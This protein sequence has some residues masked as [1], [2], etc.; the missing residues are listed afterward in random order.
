MDRTGEVNYFS[1]LPSLYAPFNKRWGSGGWRRPSS[2][3]IPG[4]WQRGNRQRGR[5]FTLLVFLPFINPANLWPSYNND[6]SFPHYMVHFDK[7]RWRGQQRGQQGEQKWRPDH[8]NRGVGIESTS[9]KQHQR[10][11]LVFWS[12]FFSISLPFLCP[13]FSRIFSSLGFCAHIAYTPLSVWMRLI[14]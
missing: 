6:R 1:P 4:L 8:L 12:S 5:A 13:F 14:I 3:G 11:H 7:R 10:E 2:G 9:T